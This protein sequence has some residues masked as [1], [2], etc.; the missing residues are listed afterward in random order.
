MWGEFLILLC[1]YYFCDDGEKTKYIVAPST[2]E[3]ESQMYAFMENENINGDIMEIQVV[4]GRN[5]FYQDIETGEILD[6]RE[7]YEGYRENYPE[8]E[9]TFLGYLNNCTSKNGFLKK[10]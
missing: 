4:K 8:K 9:I 1:V 5:T 7:I 10:I 3:A 2:E 6:E